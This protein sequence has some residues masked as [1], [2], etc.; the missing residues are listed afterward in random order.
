MLVL[1]LL[2]L[3][4]LI[5]NGRLMN[6]MLLVNSNTEGGAAASLLLTTCLDH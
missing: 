2:W 1:G 6:D 3:G 4:L 5:P